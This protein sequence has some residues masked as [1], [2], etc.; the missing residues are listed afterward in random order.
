M[1]RLA[2]EECGG[3]NLH[4]EAEVYFNPETEEFEA[5]QSLSYSL[6]WD[7]D[8]EVNVQ[9]VEEEGE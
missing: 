9:T 1:K 3:N 5:S 8:Q 7:C 4:L 6:C 2:C